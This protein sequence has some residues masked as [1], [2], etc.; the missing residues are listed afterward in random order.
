MGAWGN[1]IMD[2]DTSSDIYED[3]IEL[4]NEGEDPNN[5]SKSLIKDNQELIENPDDCNNFWFALALAQWETKSLNSV[6]FDKVKVII[7]S[8]KDLTVWRELDADEADIKKRKIVLQKFL[9]KL[10]SERKRPK[11]RQKQK[12]VIGHP[13]FPKG[14]CIT[15]KLD[16]GNFGGA[17]VLDEHE[18][19][20]LG[21]KNYIAT[22]KINQPYKPT[23]QDIEKSEL[24]INNFF[25]SNNP[26]GE[27]IWYSSDS[28]NEYEGL[29]E[30]IG[31]I[32]V[33]RNYTYGGIGTRTTA[34]WN[35]I[36]IDVDRQIEFEKD[37]QRSLH[38]FQ[39][40]DFIK[41]K[42]WWKL[43]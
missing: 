34:G 35:Y 37:N 23:I 9:E 43:K 3:F 7:E 36:K 41:D 20:K 17:I 14:T 30:I 2:N 27:I 29:F 21:G 24:L 15:F 1:G 6:V 12:P 40:K 32:K 19:L 13:I 39:V 16:N 10:Q 33:K 18:D 42:K 4:Y 28:Y 25:P 22:T 5:I 38:S 11:Q 31:Q 8:E 26:N